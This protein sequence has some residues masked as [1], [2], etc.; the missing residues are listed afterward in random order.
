MALA[1]RIYELASAMEDGNIV[2]LLAAI[3]RDDVVKLT[4]AVEDEARIKR[5]MSSNV[6]LGEEAKVTDD[7][8]V[9][10]PLTEGQRDQVKVVTNSN[11]RAKG[12]RENP[13]SVV[14]TGQDSVT[15]LE[16]GEHAAAAVETVRVAASTVLKRGSN[17]STQTA[18]KSQKSETVLDKKSEMVSDMCEK[19]ALVSE[20]GGNSAP[21]TAV[22]VNEVCTATAV[23]TGEIMHSG[24]SQL[25][26][27]SQE[28]GRLV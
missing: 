1:E 2:E 5:G 24:M 12:E 4:I 13:S 9:N 3:Q 6:A 11:R 15:G 20:G 14:K 18:A 16:T 26:Q 17:S 21:L 19:S 28:T 10:V 8:N 25:Q 7:T 22:D 23:E 27:E